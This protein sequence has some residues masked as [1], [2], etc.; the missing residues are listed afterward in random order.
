MLSEVI[1]TWPNRL[2]FVIYPHTSHVPFS[3]W[4]V[5]LCGILHA[6][7]RLLCRSWSQ[8]PVSDLK[9]TSRHVMER[10]FCASST[11]LSCCPASMFQKPSAVEDQRAWVIEWSTHV[12][13]DSWHMDICDYVFHIHLGDKVHAVIVIPVGAMEPVTR[14]L[15]C[16]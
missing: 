12:V 16:T 4:S 2:C 3:L 6:N 15:L 5:S 1:L 9:A 7:M 8:W 13:S 14:C 10:A 11:T